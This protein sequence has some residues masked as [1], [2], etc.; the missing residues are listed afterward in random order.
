MMNTES[1]VILYDY[2]RSTACYRVRIALA[3]KGIAY[4]KETIHLINEGGQQ[5]SPAYQAINP[6]RLVPSL[7]IDG[8][9]LTQSLAIIDYLE[10]RYPEPSLLPSDPLARAT[11][12]GLAQT[13]ACDVHPLNNLRV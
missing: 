6:Q 9:Y 7:F 4:T 12:L 3:H 2:F 10:S 8:H 11:V 1:N 13:I 5:H